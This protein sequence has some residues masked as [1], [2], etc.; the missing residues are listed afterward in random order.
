MKTSGRS[1][2]EGAPPEPRRR[3]PARAA[4][5]GLAALLLGAICLSCSPAQ[6]ALA[7]LSS[8]SG[9]YKESLAGFEKEWGRPAA[10]VNL[11]NSGLK[12]PAA[13]DI[14]AAFGSKAAVKPYPDNIPL[15]YWAPGLDPGQI[16]HAGVTIKVRLLPRPGILISRLKE[17][18]PGLKEL[19][20]LFISGSFTQF[21][22]DMRAAGAPLG[23]AVR[24]EKLPAADALPERLR[25]MNPKP[26]ALWL[27]P[28]PVLINAQ[29]FT[30]LKEYSWG[31]GVPL[32]S[33]SAG[34]VELGATA[35][36]AAGFG[37]IGRVTA[38]AAKEVLAGN[39]GKEEVYPEE[40]E[41]AVNLTAA[42]KTG[43]V[44]SA[45]FL[46]TVQKVFP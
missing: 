8:G 22:G 36:V 32:Y 13:A 33:G 31:N 10:S 29:T 2:K 16:D 30:T 40:I 1:S 23:I 38:K 28:D 34:L 17:L 12:I 4:G 27:P 46:K 41:T 26:D 24:A 43:V 21:I 45:D 39:G 5:T 35:S 9:S 20:A 11:A 3:L 42:A 19:R 7:V 37:E 15:I 44:F 25:A 14:I 6:E 18:Q